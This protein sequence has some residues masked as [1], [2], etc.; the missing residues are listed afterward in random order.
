VCIARRPKCDECILNN[1]CNYNK[2]NKKDK[3]WLKNL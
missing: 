3:K 2:Q 1:I